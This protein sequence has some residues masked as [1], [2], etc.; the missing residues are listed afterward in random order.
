MTSC[1]FG[2][3]VKTKLFFVAMLVAVE[4]RFVRG[5]WH[6]I[7]NTLLRKLQPKFSQAEGNRCVLRTFWLK[8]CFE[9]FLF[10]SEITKK[11]LFL[12]KFQTSVLFSSESTL[13]LSA[14][15]VVL[16]SKQSMFQRIFFKK[17]QFIVISDEKRKFSKHYF[18]QKVRGTDRLPS[19]FQMFVTKL[20]RNFHI[21]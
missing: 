17:S 5:L 2:K 6:S 4:K 18:S 13:L 3:T 10:S 9:N 16:Q 7:F 15:W 12:K 21:T 14:A 8:Q 1:L 20:N 11:W 19:V